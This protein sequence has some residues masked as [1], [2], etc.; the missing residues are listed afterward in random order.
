MTFKPQIFVFARRELGP[1]INLSESEAICWYQ[2]LEVGGVAPVSRTQCDYYT[3][4]PNVSRN[5]SAI[6][7][8][9]DINVRPYCLRVRL[10]VE[11]GTLQAPAEL[12]E[13]N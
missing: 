9:Q 7:G 13:L 2:V 6:I 1:R 10:E 5:S 12:P 8:C 11:R 4:H 3:W